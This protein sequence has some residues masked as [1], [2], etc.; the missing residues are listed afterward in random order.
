MLGL[1]STRA[2]DADKL[3]ICPRYDYFLCFFSRLRS[4]FI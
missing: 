4:I 2:N 3:H 1:E